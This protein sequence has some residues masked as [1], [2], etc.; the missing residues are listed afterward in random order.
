MREKNDI[1]VWKVSGK[2]A[3]H[4]GAIECKYGTLYEGPR[5][6]DAKFE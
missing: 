4:V 1:E 3:K 6:A 2:R 5:H